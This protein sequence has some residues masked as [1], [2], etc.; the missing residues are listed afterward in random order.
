MNK[1]Q[2]IIVSLKS[3]TLDHIYFQA[4]CKGIPPIQEI[5]SALE[6]KYAVKEDA[7]PEDG[8]LNW[9]LFGK[10]APDFKVSP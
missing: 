7:A 10:G 2:K 6:D 5:T 9:I 3:S 8:W 4:Q 1:E